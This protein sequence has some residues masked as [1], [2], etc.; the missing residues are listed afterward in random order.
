[1]IQFFGS[2]QGY[3]AGVPGFGLFILVG[4]V[5]ALNFLFGVTP[6][7]FDYGDTF[8]KDFGFLDIP[9]MGTDPATSE[10]CIFVVDVHGIGPV[11]QCLVGVQF[12]FLTDTNI[13]E[14]ETL[15]E[16]QS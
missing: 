10:S 12:F 6:R 7:T 4:E 8:M 5:D 1:M 3:E 14:P 13:T 2:I 11:V 15:F 9:V 16:L